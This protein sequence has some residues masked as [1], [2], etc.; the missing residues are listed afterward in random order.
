VGFLERLK[1]LFAF[2]WTRQEHELKWR[3]E[4]LIQNLRKRT[5]RRKNPHQTEKI[6]ELLN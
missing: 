1:L 2:R 5:V 6:S 4:P 3:V